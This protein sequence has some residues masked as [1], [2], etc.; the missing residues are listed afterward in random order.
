MVK[1]IIIGIALAL[2]VASF[3]VAHSDKKADA[4]IAY[5]KPTSVKITK[6]KN[7]YAHTYVYYD[8][9]K[10]KKCIGVQADRGKALT[11]ASLMS[12]PMLPPAGSIVAAGFAIGATLNDTHA[13]KVF[14]QAKKKKV[15]VVIEFDEYVMAQTRV[16]VKYHFVTKKK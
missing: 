13:D 10:V 7:G 6:I 15:G 3:I 2:V 4:S 8:A 11:V 1:K 16:H 9:S 14:A 5:P 12:G